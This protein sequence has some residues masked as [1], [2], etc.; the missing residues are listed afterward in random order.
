MS[1]IKRLFTSKKFAA[2]TEIR[3]QKSGGVR[4]ANK[5]DWMDKTYTG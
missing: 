2:V 3:G 5:V 4:D 1:I